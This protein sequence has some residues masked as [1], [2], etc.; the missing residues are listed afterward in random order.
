M[1]EVEKKVP[2]FKNAFPI[3]QRV[4][5]KT[6]KEFKIL[7]LSETPARPF[8]IF[9][10]NWCGYTGM[11][12]LNII[13]NFLSKD[14]RIRIIPLQ[15][16]TLQKCYNYVEH[17]KG[18]PTVIPFIHSFYE[19]Y[20][21]AE[22]LLMERDVLSNPWDNRKAMFKWLDSGSWQKLWWILL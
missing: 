13:I 20:T 10:S 16:A 12:F 15:V 14:F 17:A 2:L 4:F 11:F 8:S 1:N 22:I 6:G 7:E 19:G 18:T 21:N 9:V 3:A 5:S